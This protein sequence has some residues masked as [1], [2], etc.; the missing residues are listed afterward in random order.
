MRLNK[1][2]PVLDPHCIFQSMA[3]THVTL[4]AVKVKMIPT[5]SPELSV[6]FHQ[7][8]R[9][10]VLDPM[11]AL[12]SYGILLVK[13]LGTVMDLWVGREFWHVLDNTQFYLQH[14]EL[15]LL[16]RA[17]PDRTGYIAAF[18]APEIIQSLQDW[19]EF[20]QEIDPEQMKIF[21]VGDR[22]NESSLPKNMPPNTIRDYEL[23]ARSLT[24]RL[25]QSPQTSETLTSLLSD[26]IA[27]SASLS[28]SFILTRQYAANDSLL[29]EICLELESV[30][31][32]C[33]LVNIEDKMLAIEQ[34]YLRQLFVRVGLSKFLWSGLRFS[35]L[36]LLVP[37]ILQS[38]TSMLQGRR[39][40][41]E[42]NPISTTIND[43][44]VTEV[45]KLEHDLWSGARC[46]L[47]HF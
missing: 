7:P 40:S 43:P 30:G 44:Q 13:Q 16:N 45:N 18:S 8:H 14:P 26:T 9:T 29:P 34:D 1:L 24:D 11:L 42:Q 23:L 6:K 4:V 19:G 28:S 31:I 10:C 46:F 21:W 35:V 5:S 37:S 39:Y 47:H 32:P 20:R 2:P 36:H 33:E 25:P 15:L 41:N 27:L 22:L 17:M 3:G 38:G 12:S